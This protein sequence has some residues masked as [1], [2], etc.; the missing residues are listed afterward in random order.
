[1]K[2]CSTLSSTPVLLLTWA[3][4]QS[5]CDA[6]QIGGEVREPREQDGAGSNDDLSGAC[7]DG[8]S[9]PVDA[10]TA[11][12]LGFDPQAAV[13][14]VE[15]SHGTALAWGADLAG[16]DL[17]LTP[18][19]GESRIEVAVTVDAASL[20][21]V[22]RSP[23]AASGGD[24]GLGTTLAAAPAEGG[25][26]PDELRFDGEMRVETD[27]GA[28]DETLDVAFVATS[29]NHVTTSFAVTPGELAGSFD[30]EV[31]SPAGASAMSTRLSMAFTPGGFSGALRG[32]IEVRGSDVTSAGGVTYAVFPLG[33][34]AEG[35]VVDLESELAGELVTLLD[36]L[37]E[38]ELRWSAAEATTLSLTHET[39]EICYVSQGLGGS[40]VAVLGLATEASSAD[41]RI[42]GSWSLEA[43]VSLA[44]DGTPTSVSLLRQA[45][46]V[47]VFPAS[48]FE[49]GTGI[50]G[51]SFPEGAEASFA[52]AVEDTLGDAGPASGTLT[53]LAITSADC[54]TGDPS[55]GEGEM[56]AEPGCAGSDA[57]ELET[58]LLRA[59]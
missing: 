32:I 44:A 49:E 56:Q 38:L 36:S 59:L 2:P 34:C 25:S 16:Y 3:L 11:V 39:Q 1:M 52:L 42:D 41:G 30:V 53:I 22:E 27:N 40:D 23:R 21:I 12:A 57:E 10:G 43:R 14:L 28:L 45:Y 9:R 55:S 8:Q 54:T 47:D 4:L 13:D 17:V 51:F 33:S 20:R 7:E 18:A 50:A 5:G 37:N 48:S 15:G 35:A 6:G 46:M 31:Q 29:A 19:A 24:E 26:C 58:A